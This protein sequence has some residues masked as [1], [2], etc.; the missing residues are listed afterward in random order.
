MAE[1]GLGKSP[2]DGRHLSAPLSV[3]RVLWL[4]SAF[5]R[6]SYVA[7]LKPAVSIA[8]RTRAL[9]R[10]FNSRSPPGFF[11]FRR[12]V[13]VEGER[14]SVYFAARGVKLTGPPDQSDQQIIFIHIARLQ[15]AIDF[16]RPDEAS[17]AQPAFAPA[18]EQIIDRSQEQ[19]ARQI[20][21]AEL[22]LNRTCPSP[23]ARAGRR[24]L[25]TVLSVRRRSPGAGRCA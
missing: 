13:G 25:H 4:N 1:G 20:F 24:I 9:T 16:L 14:V 19:L 15:Q 7:G 2:E 8:L 23:R 21:S 11:A 10:A 18:P 22:K 3:S 6:V 17:P 5:G 12:L